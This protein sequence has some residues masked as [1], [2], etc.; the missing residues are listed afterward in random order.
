MITIVPH[1]KSGCEITLAKDGDVFQYL[2][3]FDADMQ[4]F[5]SIDFSRFTFSS[6]S[7]AFDKFTKKKIKKYKRLQIQIENNKAEPFGITKI[8]KTYTFGNYAKR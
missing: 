1:Y 4:S 3:S 8:V 7:V 5:D 6:N 2:G